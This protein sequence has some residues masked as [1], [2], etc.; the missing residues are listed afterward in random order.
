MDCKSCCMSKQREGRLRIN[1]QSGRPLKTAFNLMVKP[2]TDNGS[3]LVREEIT[4]FFPRA[5]EKPEGNLIELQ[6][7]EIV[8]VILFDGGVAAHS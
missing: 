1:E 8:Q 4:A 3:P 7:K 2:S 5:E 6:T